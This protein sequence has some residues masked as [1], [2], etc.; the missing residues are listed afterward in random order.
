MAAG[1]DLATSTSVMP[2]TCRRG[3]SLPPQ[4]CMSLNGEKLEEL[5]GAGGTACSSRVGQQTRAVWGCSGE[6]NAGRFPFL[7]SRPHADSSFVTLTQN[8]TGKEF[9]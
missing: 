6:H 5:R 7:F 3:W 1:G 4:H 9:S 2:A 8:H